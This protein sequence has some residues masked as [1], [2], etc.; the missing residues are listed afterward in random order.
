VKREGVATMPEEDE[1]VAVRL[2]LE[3]EAS[4][5][6]HARSM[7]WREGRRK[8]GCPVPLPGATKLA[9]A[10]ARRRGEEGCAAAVLLRGEEGQ[11]RRM[12]GGA[13]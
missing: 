11:T 8:R 9:R 10:M 1:E 13:R 4:E 3:E 12:G 2:P 7:L 6:I 5:P